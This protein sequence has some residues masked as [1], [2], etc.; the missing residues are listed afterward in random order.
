MVAQSRSRVSV[1]VS[2]NFKRRHNATIGA[3]RTNKYL[4]KL[5]LNPTAPGVSAGVDRAK[6]ASFG[7]LYSAA[8]TLKKKVKG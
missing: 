4:R 2:I 1:S 3:H 5:G 7:R 8:E 6:E